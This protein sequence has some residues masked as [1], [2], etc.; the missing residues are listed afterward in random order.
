MEKLPVDK[1]W[2]AATSRDPQGRVALMLCESVLHVLVEE[3]VLTKAK[4]MEAI[5]TVAELTRE[6]ADGNPAIDAQIAADLVGAI[7]E[8]FALKD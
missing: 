3:G 2:E 6:M 5:E 8:S 1:G 4:A 7:A